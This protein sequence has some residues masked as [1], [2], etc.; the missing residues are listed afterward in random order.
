VDSLD[1]QYSY[2]VSALDKNNNESAISN[3]VTVSAPLPSPELVSPAGGSTTYARGE[4]LVWRRQAGAL[5]YRVQ[6]DSTGTFEDGQL[7]FNVQTRDTFAVPTG[8]VAQKT[9]SWRVIAANQAAESPASPTRTFTT[10]WLKPP[11]PL[12]PVNKTNIARLTTFQW[13]SNGA[14][15]YHLRAVDY[16][17]RIT[18][19]DTT[20]VDTMLTSTTVFA[21]T[22]VHL[23]YVQA[24]NPYGESDWSA[25]SRYRTGA[26]LDVSS[27]ER[28][29]P[30]RFAL[31][32][33]FPNPFNPSTVIPFQL[34]AASMVRLAVYDLLGRE[35]ALLVYDQKAA[36]KYE[37]RLDGKALA[38]GV[39]LC[40]LIAG[41]YRET[42][43]IVLMR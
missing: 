10:G 4:P 16:I 5:L 40:R 15:Q 23:W 36:G 25:E 29:V 1:T 28:D 26:V 35:V 33:N 43:K 13:S 17:T 32:Q 12:F 22:T 31:E 38:S 34:P 7:L 21:A 39:Y 3:I 42:R 20:T 27:A 41:N 18:V 37:V 19:L 8:L 9:Y 6:L 30:E 11:I 14:T 24:S 2:A